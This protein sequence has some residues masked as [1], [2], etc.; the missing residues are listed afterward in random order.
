MELAAHQKTFFHSLLSL[1]RL[2]HFL[3]YCFAFFGP[4]GTLL[5]P[6]F[7]PNAFRF[8]HFL[9]I[10]F[11]LFLIKLKVDEWKTILIFAPFL[12]YCLVS[13]YFTHNRIY[14]VDSYPLFR[15]FLFI[16]Q[17]LFMFGAA[18]CLKVD[19]KK[20]I[21]FY[22][23][24]FFIS[25]LVGYIFFIGFYSGF[26]SFRTIE[27]FSVETQM[28][29]GLLR[30]S[31]GTYPNEYGNI[32]SFA[33][34]SLLLLYAKKKRFLTL[35]FAALTFIALLLT[36]TRTA[37]ISFGVTLVYLC[38]TST[39][40]RKVMFKFLLFGTVILFLLKEYSINIF[41]IFIR[42][43]K[44]IS[45][46][47]GSAGIRLSYWIKGFKD[48]DQN[49]IFGNGFSANIYAH[50]IYLELLFELGIMGALLL[51]L[52]VIYYLSKNSHSIQKLFVDREKETTTQ[53]MIIG[54]IHTF[55]F[56]LTNHNMHHHLTWLSFLLF[57]ASLKRFSQVRWNSSYFSR[58]SA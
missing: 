21:S 31:P 56:A 27:H 35:L 42:G 12:L 49:I 8:Y 30:F 18:F 4:L 51:V 17:C 34:S 10:F 45:L 7:M 33:L 46:M 41:S 25:L 53:I 38:F 55:L 28:G 48:L 29:W 43:I 36:T 20:L 22:L 50:N 57:N 52:T 11:P 23:A 2:Q 24:G 16:S 26:I 54:L 39:E 1:G 32:G 58:T 13:A 47:E 5:S 6:S 3:I 15:S 19:Q 37:Y 44:A 9:L 40:L 14:E